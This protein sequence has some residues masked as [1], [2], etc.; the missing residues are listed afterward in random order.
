M[1]EK[2]KYEFPDSLLHLES[3]RWSTIEG[4]PDC[5]TDIFKRAVIM[6]PFLRNSIG[7]VL[8]AS[9]CSNEEHFGKIVYYPG[10]AIM[11]P[12]IFTKMD[13]KEIIGDDAEK[14]SKNK[15]LFS[16]KGITLAVPRA[17]AVSSPES[18]WNDSVYMYLCRDK[19]SVIP[20]NI[21][22]Y[23]I[24]YPI[25]KAVGCDPNTIVPLFFNTDDSPKFSDRGGMVFPPLPQWIWV[26]E[27][28]VRPS[29][30]ALCE[31]FKRIASDIENVLSDSYKFE[32][33]RLTAPP[34]VETCLAHAKKCDVFFKKMEKTH[35][36]EDACDSD[37]EWETSTLSN[38]DY[39]LAGECG[40]RIG[41]KGHTE[42]ERNIMDGF[43]SSIAKT[44]YK[45]ISAKISRCRLSG[46]EPD[47]DD[48]R[49]Q[50]EFALKC[51]EEQKRFISYM[52]N[53][54]AEQMQHDDRE[55]CLDEEGNPLPM[56]DDG[57]VLDD[58]VVSNSHT[59][60]NVTSVAAFAKLSEPTSGKKRLLKKRSSIITPLSPTTDM[61]DDDIMAMIGATLE[62][63][64]DPKPE[65]KPETK[66][67]A[68][69]VKKAVASKPAQAP[70][71]VTPEKAAKLCGK[72]PAAPPLKTKPKV[73]ATEQNK[74]KRAP[75]PEENENHGG[76]DDDE[77]D[78]DSDDDDG[79]DE[80]NSDDDS[81]PSDT[82]ETDDDRE[83]RN[84]NSDESAGESDEEPEPEPQPTPM[85]QEQK[86]KKKM[87]VLSKTTVEK[88]SKPTVSKTVDPPAKSKVPRSSGTASAVDEMFKE[89]YGA[90]Q[91]RTNAA[92]RRFFIERLFIIIVR[93]AN[94]KRKAVTETVDAA[95]YST[96][97]LLSGCSREV[98]A[99]SIARCTLI[100]NAAN[101]LRTQK[102]VEVELPDVFKTIRSQTKGN[103]VFLNI[104]DLVAAYGCGVLEPFVV[105]PDEK[106][107]RI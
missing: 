33:K 14:I 58:F 74:S 21:V 69:S 81:E 86:K 6:L 7:K 29:P 60:G 37:E 22:E 54:D 4:E 76:N 67:L 20:R 63:T 71:E 94:E 47:P 90:T 10:C 57:Y 36:R 48:L 12:D 92:Q 96:N 66:P 87:P 72:R 44:N 77:D 19:Y 101:N 24:V 32:N 8:G 17:E 45:I 23:V 62:P 35:A 61:D 51:E 75:K 11:T 5:M 89:I 42:H 70:S 9:N 1:G 82:E 91:I 43:A 27:G 25:V 3:S 59:S 50:A 30:D 107:P 18:I 97:H 39:F 31:S 95:F 78:D 83:E 64:P 80:V 104:V 79:G 105:P 56:S 99:A 46:N 106:K 28:D 88:L 98:T 38:R 40:E 41:E 65:P 55:E 16:T 49:L 34:D 102:P 53:P 93:L 2:F 73:Q 103:P 100:T 68:V 13:P 15:L 26:A 85:K 52:E 84:E